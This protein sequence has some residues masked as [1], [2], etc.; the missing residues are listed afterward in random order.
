MVIVIGSQK[1]GSGKSTLAVNLCVALMPHGSVLLVDA[2]PQAT[3][4]RWCADRRSVS[5]AKPVQCVQQFGALAEELERLASEFAQVIIDPAGRDNVE[6][7]S[8]MTMAD[9][10]IVP[11]RPS[12]P[13]LDTLPKM[14]PSRSRNARKCALDFVGFRLVLA[15]P[16]QSTGNHKTRNPANGR[17]QTGFRQFLLHRQKL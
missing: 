10:L 6:L 4:S 12:Q 8:A 2:D 16:R 13:D 15:A 1:G 17:R 14:N 11:F 7:R 9:L 3:S 5:A